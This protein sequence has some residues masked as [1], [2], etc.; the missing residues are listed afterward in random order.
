VL[1]ANSRC[2][3]AP[4]H[5][6]QQGRVPKERCRTELLII[7][8]AD[9]LK[10]NGLEQLRDWF[11]RF[12]LGLILIGVPASTGNWPATRSS[13]AGS[14]S[15]TST[16]HSTPKTSPPYS[17]NTGN[18]SAHPTATSTPTLKWSA[19]SSASPV[20]TF[21]SSIDHVALADQARRAAH[22]RTTVLSR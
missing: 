19:P 15:P 21:A 10:T 17:R 2:H 1:A 16:N 14:A 18:N 13:T 9:R 7:D 12:D 3:R 11:D 22:G 6:S 8:E 20:A 4:R 5:P